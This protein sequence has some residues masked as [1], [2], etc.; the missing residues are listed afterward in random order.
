MVL[1]HKGYG[2]YI[3]CDDTPLDEFAFTKEDETTV[4]CYICSQAGKVCIVNV[5]D[6]AQTNREM[7]EL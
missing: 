2:A 5:C 4:S 6:P 1:K 7:P 3:S